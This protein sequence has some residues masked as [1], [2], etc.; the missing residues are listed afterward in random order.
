MYYRINISIQLI[1]IT[2]YRINDAMSG[3]WF[4]L[5]SSVVYVNG[6]GKKTRRSHNNDYLTLFE[7]RI[8]NPI[9]YHQMFFFK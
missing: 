6:H 8:S 1:E 5:N 4:V 9:R 2:I 3:K 7:I